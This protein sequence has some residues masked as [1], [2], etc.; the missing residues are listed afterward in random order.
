[1]VVLFKKLTKT[2]GAYGGVVLEIKKNILC[3]WWYRFR[4]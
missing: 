2:F 1:M 3:I 4:D